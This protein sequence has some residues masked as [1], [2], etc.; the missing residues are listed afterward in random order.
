[1]SVESYVADKLTLR[2]QPR[3]LQTGEV[4]ELEAA[5]AAGS[6]IGTVDQLTPEQKSD[7]F[8]SILLAQLA[9]TGQYD[10]F[11]ETEQWYRKYVEILGN[12]GWIVSQ[13]AFH[14]VRTREARFRMDV[15]GLQAIKNI[16]S[17]SG[18]SVLESSLQVLESLPSDDNAITL[19]DSKATLTES[20]NF[21]LGTADIGDDGA[22]TVSLG[23]FRFKAN[24]RR[25]RFLFFSWNSQEVEF[26][27]AVQV[28]KLNQ[29][30][31]ARDVIAKR[32]NDFIDDYIWG[33]KLPDAS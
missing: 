5:V 33:L 7:V 18:L 2:T 32:L 6:V 8:H 4:G 28:M 30:L 15:A 25:Q 24:V 31:K 19:F 9:A 26:W 10:R 27:A 21:Q 12:I 16:A 22:V 13:V 29:E 3:A 23:A 20:G 11:D 17:T 1:M 14:Q